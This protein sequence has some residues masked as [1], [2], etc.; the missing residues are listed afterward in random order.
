MRTS[1]R[2]GD[3]RNDVTITYK[4]NATAT[5]SDVQSIAIYGKQAQNIAT[6]LE[7][8][9]DAQEQADFY[10]ALEPFQRLSSSQSVFH[11]A[12]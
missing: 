4:A 5:A 12:T 9:V 3:I 1:K 8:A 7:N 10:L 2:I 11:W 6:S